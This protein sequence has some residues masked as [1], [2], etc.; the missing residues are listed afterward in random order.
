[1]AASANKDEDL[2][3]LMRDPA[4]SQPGARGTALR[5]RVRSGFAS[6]YPGPLPRDE[7]GRQADSTS[8]S[9]VVNVRAYS[10]TRDGR[11][12]TGR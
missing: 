4:Y 1:M 8:D 2:R 5:E 7:T 10:R 11:T 12:G 3:T 6:R 9:G